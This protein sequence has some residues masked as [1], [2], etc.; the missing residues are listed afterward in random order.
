MKK[1]IRLIALYLP[2][3]YPTA[4]NNKWW[5]NGFTEWTNVCKAKKLFPGHN[6]PN[7]PADLGFYDLRLPQ[8]R[9]AQAQLAMEHGIEGFCYYHYWFGNGRMELD[10]PLREV[11]DSGQP[12]YPFCLCWA[13]ESWYAKMWNKDGL[14]TKKSLVEQTYPGHDDY[15]RHF[16]YLLPAFRDKRYICVDGKPL[17]MIYQPLDFPQVQSFIELWQSLAKDNGLAGIYFVGHTRRVRQEAEQ[18]FNRGFDAVNVL[19]LTEAMRRSTCL[20]N[21]GN[22]LLR[23]LFNFPRVCRYKD[24]YPML[25]GEEEKQPNIFPCI[26]P[27]WDHTPR[28]G[29]GGSV[30]HQATPALFRKHVEQVFEIVQEHPDQQ[31]IVFIKSWNEW[32]EGNY[33]EPDLRYGC[34]YLNEL[35][36]ALLSFGAGQTDT[37]VHAQ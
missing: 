34:G 26:V 22:K 36:N 21:L 27:N 11:L 19:R 7:V 12:D 1:K 13:N 29:S 32:G 30:L 6:Q 5:G 2:Q 14:Q 25:V 3:Y 18:N 4:S 17:F 8:T 31:R 28:S 24:V 10:L 16:N 9:E 37:D 23:T 15:V 35:H 20:K 33:M